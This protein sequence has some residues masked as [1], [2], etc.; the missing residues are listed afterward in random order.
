MVSAGPNA[1][2][3]ASSRTTIPTAP[4]ITCVSVGSPD[5]AVIASWSENQNT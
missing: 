5:R 2:R 1:R 3:D 4:R